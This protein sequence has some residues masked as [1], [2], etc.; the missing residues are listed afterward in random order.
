VRLYISTAEA[1]ELAEGRIPE[2]VAAKA[3]AKLKPAEPMAGQQ[4]I[5]DVLTEEPHGDADAA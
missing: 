3:A 4:S 1:R 2:T 5:Y